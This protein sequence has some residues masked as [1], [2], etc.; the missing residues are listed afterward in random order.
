MENNFG[1]TKLF[2]RGIVLPIISFN[3]LGIFIVL[4]IYVIRLNPMK[5]NS[6]AQMKNKDANEAANRS[7]KDVSIIDMSNFNLKKQVSTP[8]IKNASKLG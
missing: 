5:Q 7:N 8:V 3:L 1:L 2:S 6:A 4:T